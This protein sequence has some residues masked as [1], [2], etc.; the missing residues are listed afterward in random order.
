MLNGDNVMRANPSNSSFSETESKKVRLS[1]AKKIRP[2]AESEQVETLRLSSGTDDH[3]SDVNDKSIKS[4][5]EVSAPANAN[6][7][8]PASGGLRKQPSRVCDDMLKSSD[9]CLP[10]MSAFGGKRNPIS[11]GPART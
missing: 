11:E 4:D 6:T 1:G 10:K 9:V 3:S 2:F 5:K 7:Q 8:G